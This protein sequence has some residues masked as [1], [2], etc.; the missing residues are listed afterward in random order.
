MYAKESKD[1]ARQSGAGRQSMS[2][3][4]VSVKKAVLDSQHLYNQ[5]TTI[6]ELSK[7]PM[8]SLS[9]LDLL[10]VIMTTSNIKFDQYM[11]F[12]HDDA[13][14]FNRSD[15]ISMNGSFTKL[16][17]KTYTMNGLLSSLEADI[18]IHFPKE[19]LLSI[20]KAAEIQHAPMVHFSY[21]EG[22][23]ESKHV[24]LLVEVNCKHVKYIAD[25][26]T[27]MLKMIDTEQD[28]V[29]LVEVDNTDLPRTDLLTAKEES[30]LNMGANSNSRQ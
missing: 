27:Q 2:G 3:M 12:R 4:N 15:K 5:I 28:L 7:R 20:Q 1:H 21:V 9:P 8:F 16:G 14:N 24:R 25:V 29:A 10:R 30:R 22:S 11:T 19:T 17:I 6:D 18:T 23:L 13:Y 26:K